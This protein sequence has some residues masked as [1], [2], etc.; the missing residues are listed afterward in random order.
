MKQIWDHWFV[1]PLLTGQLASIEAKGVT[2]LDLKS[3]C[4]GLAL[5][6][7]WHLVVA[8][9]LY[10]CHSTVEQSVMLTI[11]FDSQPCR[12]MAS[13]SGSNGKSSRPSARADWGEAFL[14]HLGR[15]WAVREAAIRVSYPAF[16]WGVVHKVLG[17]KQPPS[18]KLKE[19][20][21][22]LM[23]I[24]SDLSA[25]AV[26]TDL[27]NTM[28]QKSCYRHSLH[29]NCIAS[30]LC[31]N[32]PLHQVFFGSVAHVGSLHIANACSQRHIIQSYPHLEAASLWSNETVWTSFLR[33][34]LKRK[35]LVRRAKV[36][37]HCTWGTDIS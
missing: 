34:S 27:L 32:D 22:R 10:G 19:S 11:C 24:W 20:Q 17:T 29:E 8:R 28:L 7:H 9:L 31:P 21:A 36:M 13:T 6:Q 5:A 15:S 30:R 4:L 37:L 3:Q 2:C 1:C 35:V 26:E 25:H 23:L 12:N 33:Q 16:V 14:Q 18:L